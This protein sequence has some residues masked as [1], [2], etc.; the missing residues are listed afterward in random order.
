MLN[1]VMIIGNC[2]KDP[3][4]RFTPQGKP[5]TSFSVAVSRKYTVDSERKEETEWFNVIAWNKLAEI[6]NQYL[7]KGSKVFVEGSL[8]THSWEKDGETKYRTELIATN[9]EL[10]DKRKLEN[11]STEEES[12]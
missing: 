5:V 12:F 11:E 2:G 10:L 8:R 9:I 3:E 6:C 7:N 1:K 4:M